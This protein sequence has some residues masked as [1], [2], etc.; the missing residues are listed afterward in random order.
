[1]ENLV[2]KIRTDEGLVINNDGVGEKTIS[3][4]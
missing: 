3:K 2:V 1:M 4:V